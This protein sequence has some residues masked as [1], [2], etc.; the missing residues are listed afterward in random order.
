LGSNGKFVFR[1]QVIGCVVALLL[2][3]R[4]HGDQPVDFSRQPDQVAV[5]DSEVAR[6]VVEGGVLLFACE[7]GALA[8]LGPIV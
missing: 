4:K 2:E 8:F 7:E 3:V 6:S 1:G 5:Q